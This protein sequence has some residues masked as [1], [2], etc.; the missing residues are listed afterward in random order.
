MSLFNVDKSD[1][2]SKYKSKYVYIIKINFIN[3]LKNHSIKCM[4]D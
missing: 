1:R 4:I 3:V 2:I